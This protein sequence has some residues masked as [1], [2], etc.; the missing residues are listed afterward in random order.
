M[1]V[2][3]RLQLFTFFIFYQFSWGSVYAP[4]TPV[5]INQSY[6][7]ITGIV[8][9]QGETTLPGSSVVIKDLRLGTVT[10]LNGKFVLL[11]VPVGQYKLE[12]SYIGAISQTI[13]VNVTNGVTLDLGLITLKESVN[14]LGEVVVTAS[15]EGQQKAYNQQKNSDQI[16][17]IVSADLINQFPDINVSEALQ[18]VSGVNIERSNGEGTNIR[19][20]GTPRNYTT[21][22]IDGAQLPNTDGNNRTESLDL[23]P[24]E[25]LSSMEI[26]KS[27]LPENDGDAIGGSVN[28]KTPTA[29]SKKG[30]VSG[31][32]AGGYA[33][34]NQ[35][36]TFRTQLK[37]S[38]RFLKKKLGL[39]LGASY[40]SNLG[41]EDRTSG[42]W[43]IVEAGPDDNVQNVIALNEFQTR[44]TFNFRE[45]IG[46][47]TT[48]DYKFS[49][50]SQIFLTGSYYALK[51]E[52]ERYRTRFRARGDFPE[53]GNPLVA[54]SVGGGARIQKDIAR[55]NQSRDNITI[56]LGGNHLINNSV[57]LD[58]GLNVSTSER[59]EEIFRSVF[60]ANGIQ[61]DIDI[62]NSDFP[63]YKPRNFDQ[64]NNS[65]FNFLGYQIEAP[66]RITGIN[67][68]GFFNF[69]HPFKIGEK[70]NSQLKMGTKIRLQE[71]SR[72]RTNIQYINYSGNFTMDQV[73]GENQ[74]SILGGRYQLG[75]FP[76][77][78]RMSRHFATNSALYQFDKEE[79]S[80]NELSN[81]FD[82]QEDIFA[83]YIQNKLSIGKFSAVFGLRYEKTYASYQS[84]LV[85]REFGNLT[86]QPIDGGLNYDFLLPSISTK[87]ALSPNTNLR[88]S[89]Y[90]SFARPDFINLIP[91]EIINFA[92]LQ[93]RRGN[94]ELN[95]AF[96]R[97]VD[98]MFEHYLKK[99]GTLT[100]GLFYK[101]IKDFIFEQQS[102]ILD[103]PLLEGFQLLQFVNG[104]VANVLGLEATVSKKFTFLPGFLS[105]F[106]MYANYTYVDSKSNFI[107]RDNIGGVDVVQ[108]RNGLPFVGQADHTANAALYYDKGK[109][110]IRASLNY[111]SKSYLSF[112]I[113]PFNDFI[114]EERVQLDANA[115][116][117]I[118]NNL[119]LFFEAQNLTDSPVIE[120]NQLRNRLSEY[121]LFGSFVRFGLNFKF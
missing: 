12:I 56:T 110:S 14:Q 85:R 118:T 20:R 16:K 23:I 26:S 76:S 22:S 45:R 91:G 108:E 2:L 73:I 103:N 43:N 35:G 63:Q 78:S 96:A 42:I 84:N 80:F 60:S 68:T 8:L 3:G 102:F 21:V 71:N 49:E 6:G 64:T 15:I 100:F 59:D 67:K 18:R 107:F 65:L 62:S 48:I 98:F 9:G 70:V 82:A 38:K 36:E 94:A 77:V 58:Y 109:F 93:V 69:E 33:T 46:A 81:T 40:Y 89:Y 4:N 86:S 29:T 11:R 97:N 66:I 101:N 24:A 83:S 1:K 53:F 112:S 54:G 47:N 41:G 39:I 113:D 32:I 88:L 31:S 55:S 44:P 104:D 119:S 10:D 72:R 90:A 120:Y 115:S 106:G 37:Y 75:N 27:L 111:Q 95:P 92:T 105:G 117:K 57:K 74:G 34:I 61:F 87:Y 52:S 28:L 50:N 116:Y 25:L 30:K 19:I 51:D 79:S 114:L 7:S 99:D 5:I 121:K 17:S 13:N